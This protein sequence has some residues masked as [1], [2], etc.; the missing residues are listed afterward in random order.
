MRLFRWNLHRFNANTVLHISITGEICLAHL[1]IQLLPMN[2]SSV[3]QFLCFFEHCVCFIKY[4]VSMSTNS[5]ACKYIAQ[6]QRYPIFGQPSM[7]RIDGLFT[8]LIG[9]NNSV[10]GFRPTLTH[11][12]KCLCFLRRLVTPID[13]RPSSIS[14]FQRI[15]GR[16]L[17]RLPQIPVL[18]E[19]PLPYERHGRASVAAG[20]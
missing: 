12:S 4:D 2:V 9:H 13:D 15:Q 20:Y 18:P 17:P 11:R 16:P 3:R 7:D 10:N 1:P 8:Y 6:F 5:N 19:Q 14:P